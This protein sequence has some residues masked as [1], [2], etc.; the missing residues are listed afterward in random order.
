MSLGVEAKR[1]WNLWPDRTGFAIYYHM[2]ESALPSRR[3]ISF[4]FSRARR[5]ESR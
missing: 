2:T 5:G 1:R 3:R 4:L